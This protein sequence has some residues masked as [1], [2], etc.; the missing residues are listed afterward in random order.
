MAEKVPVADLTGIPETMLWP[1][2]GRAAETRRPDA[3]LI[4]PQA[5]RIADAIEY[6]YARSFRKPNFGHV[7]RALCID[8]LLRQWLAKH[9]N[10]QVVALGEG[11]ETQVF[12]VDNGN[13]RWLSVDLP[14][15]IAV[16]SRFVPDTDRHRNLACSALDFR[17]MEAVDPARGVFVTMAGLLMYFQPDEV[18]TLVAGIAAQFPL[19]EMAFDTIPRWASRKS[20]KGWQLTPHY[21]TPPMPWGFDRNERDTIKSWHPNIADVHEAPYPGGRG[22]LY[23]AMLPVLQIVPGVRN[24][25]PTV[26]H[27]RCAPTTIGGELE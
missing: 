3:R 14:A 17:W 7:L 12:R 5:V 2:Y 20:L 21:R 10:G 27:L 24:K 22:F 4:D 6:D 26:W 13:V 9:P 25:L 11:L 8:G 16:R 15:A 1:L 18:Q 19:A 23:R